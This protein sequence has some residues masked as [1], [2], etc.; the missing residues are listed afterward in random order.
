LAAMTVL[1]VLLGKTLA[2]LP[3]SYLHY[4]EIVLFAAFGFKLLFDAS[5]MPAKTEPD[6]VQEAIEAVNTSCAKLSPI[7]ALSSFQPFF[8]IVLQA[9]SLTFVAEWGDRTQIATIALATS[10][11]PLGVTLGAVLGHSICAAI[12]VIC[13]RW[14]ASRISERMMTAIGGC[15]FLLFGLVAAAD[16]V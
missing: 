10:Y 8:S 7:Q 12:A 15:L 5:R 13:G 9:F 11:A 1:S 3:K 6:E 2:F 16:G 14:V 4:G